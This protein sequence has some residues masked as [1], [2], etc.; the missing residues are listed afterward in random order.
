MGQSEIG[1]SGR[2]TRAESECAGEKSKG[3]LEGGDQTRTCLLG[4]HYSDMENIR[5]LD[6]R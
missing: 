4:G 3:K 5:C 1:V 6:Q 2:D